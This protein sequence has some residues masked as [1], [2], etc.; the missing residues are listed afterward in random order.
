MANP[1]QRRKQRSATHR[2][3]SH[4]RHAKRNLKKTPPIRGPAILYAALGL[5]HTLNPSASGGVE[6]M[7]SAGSSEDSPVN[8]TAASTSSQTNSNS[9]PP[10]PKGHGRILRDADGT[11]LGIEL[12]DEDEE[13]AQDD[14]REKDMEETAPEVDAY[15]REKWITGLGGGPKGNGDGNVVEELERISSVRHSSTATTLSASISGAGPRQASAGEAAYLQRLVDK[16]GSDV[17]QMARDRKLNPEQR[18]AGQL[19]RSV[20]RCFE[21]RS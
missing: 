16:Y 11:V 13:M 2:A 12:A 3:V 4:A 18:T 14:D 10:I 9:A 5:V 19:R 7:E 6:P 8:L 1:R 17:E 21:T 15:V 20:K